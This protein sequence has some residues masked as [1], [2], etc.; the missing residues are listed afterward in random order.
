[1]K[2]DFVLSVSLLSS[3][4]SLSSPFITVIP[5][6]LARAFSFYLQLLLP[7]HNTY[8]QVLIYIVASER[9]INLR[10]ELTD[11]NHT[12]DEDILLLKYKQCL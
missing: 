2:S 12:C 1:M 4:L 8:Y 5:G 3:R 9:A 7:M 10:E 11:K 6:A